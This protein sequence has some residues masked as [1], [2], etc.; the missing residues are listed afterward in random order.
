MAE[1]FATAI[2]IEEG[3]DLL[4]LITA[5]EPSFSNIYLMKPGKAISQNTLYHPKLFNFSSAI[6]HNLLFLHAISDGCD[7][8]SA[9]YCQ[10]S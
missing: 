5:K 4:I 9:F 10:G 6:E 1:N 2:I 3:T 7:T 8:I